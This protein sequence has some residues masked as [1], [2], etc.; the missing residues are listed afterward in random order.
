MEGAQFEPNRPCAGPSEIM[1]K[2]DWKRGASESRQQIELLRARWPKA[3]PAKGHEVRPLA[4]AA[5]AIAE[6]LG[7]SHAY[8]K[9]VLSPWVLREAYCRAVLAHAMR[10][11]LD[12]SES[13]LTV[14][15]DARAM[16]TAR[17]ALLAAR[18]AQEPERKAQEAERKARAAAAKPP[19]PAPLPE[20]EPE[21]A[22]PVAPEPAPEPPRARKILTLGASAKEALLKRGLGTTEV[23]T[24]IQRRAR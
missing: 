7:W 4:N 3:F 18:K 14:E 11:N 23:V 5:P 20:P 17:L 22:P 10:I 16:A 19:Q 15:D 2:S 6:A 8:A 13:E 12:G 24:T 1:S 21:P 9:G